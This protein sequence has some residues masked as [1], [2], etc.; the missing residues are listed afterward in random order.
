MTYACVV[1]RPLP[2]SCTWY[3][4]KELNTRVFATTLYHTYPMAAQSAA[5]A[6][7]GSSSFIRELEIKDK[8]IRI[9]QLYVG[10]VGCVVWDAAIVLCK[11][12]E[13][14]Y[15]F[16]VPGS[17]AANMDGSDSH[18]QISKPESTSDPSYWNGKRVIDIGSG[19]GVV[20]IAAGVLG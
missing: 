10:D 12:L 6:G 8:T 15:Y 7:G 5:G 18:T 16:P 3:T 13:N 4:R 9:K 2:I 14:N 20:G 17:G 11:F 1:G 19:T